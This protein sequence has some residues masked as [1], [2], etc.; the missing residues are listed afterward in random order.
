MDTIARPAP[1]LSCGDV[2][3]RRW[4]AA[5]AA[6]ACRLV[7]ESAEHLR[8]W[9]T[10]AADYSVDAAREYV[11]A[12]ERN[13]ESGAEFNY[14]IDAGGSPAGSAGLMARIGPGGLEIGYWVHR[15]HTGRGVATAAAAALTE[16]A[17]GLPG[18]DVVEIL[19]DLNN[20]ASAAVPR[21]LG[22]ERVETVPGRFAPAPGDSGTCV[23]W[24]RTR[25]RRAT[26]D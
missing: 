21:K 4:R 25:P 2:T 6:L 13:W 8:P 17:F 26:A 23:L 20:A 22:Y 18:I 7:S 10:W 24:R 9:M 16:A 12:C 14:L 1:E 5:D 19:H 3:L 15:D 11:A